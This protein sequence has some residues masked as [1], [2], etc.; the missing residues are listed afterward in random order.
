MEHFIQPGDPLI[1][2]GEHVEWAY[3]VTQVRRFWPHW[4]GGGAGLTETEPNTQGSVAIYGENSMVQVPTGY[5]L[6]IREMVC[7]EETF[8]YTAIA[9]EPTVIV[10]VAADTI[11]EISR[12]NHE[13]KDVFLQISAENLAGRRLSQL[14]SIRRVSLQ[15][16]EEE[17]WDPEDDGELP[18]HR[19]NYPRKRSHGGGARSSLVKW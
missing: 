10:T 12:T 4:G 5:I 19:Y 1:V 13:L 8:M 7:L 6:G 17:P 16:A 2:S 18:M 3:F 9:L 11:I 15:D 14:N